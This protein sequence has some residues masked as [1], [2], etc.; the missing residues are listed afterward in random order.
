MFEIKT[1]PQETFELKLEVE[2]DDGCVSE[3]VINV[4]EPSIKLIKRFDE[5]KDNKS[6][7]KICEILSAVL[8][9]N[10]ED[11]KISAKDLEIFTA[12][13]LSTLFAAYTKWYVDVANSK[14]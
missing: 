13:E 9:R 1:L 3:T 8:S 4:Y 10:M 12:K 11:V 14:N 7:D 5:L 6:T 2:N